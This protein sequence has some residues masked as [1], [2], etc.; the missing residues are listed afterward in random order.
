VTELMMLGGRV[1]PFSLMEGE[2]QKSFR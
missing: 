2:C 1:D